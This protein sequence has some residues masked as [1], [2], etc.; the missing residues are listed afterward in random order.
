MKHTGTDPCY[1]MYSSPSSSG[2][3]VPD[4]PVDDLVIPSLTD[5]TDSSSGGSESETLELGQVMSDD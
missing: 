2:S 3:G 4:H 1:D 5:S